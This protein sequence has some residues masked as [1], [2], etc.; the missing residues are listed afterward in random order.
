MSTRKRRSRSVDP[1]KGWLDHRPENI[2]DLDTVFQ[3]Q[4]NRAK[5]I[6]KL[7]DSKTVTDAK[8]SKYAL[9]TQ[10][11]VTKWIGGV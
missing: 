4:M 7:V 2:L 5:S 8:I 6:T 11:Q 10:E 1:G 9:T 3:P